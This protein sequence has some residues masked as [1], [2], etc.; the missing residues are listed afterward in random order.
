MEF[1]H[2]LILLGAGFAAGFVAGLVG[3][4]GGVIFAPVL[5]FYF[6]AIGIP[7]DLI[8]QLTIGSSLFC[9]MLVAIASAWTQHGKDTIITRI[10]AVAG[11]LS[12]FA[13]LLT[14]RYITTQPWYS[15]AI[16][17]V[18]FS[19][20]LLTVAVRMLLSRSKS[21]R[22]DAEDGRRRPSWPALAGTGTVAGAVS[23]ATG[24]GGGVI[25]VPA[26][27][28]FMRLPIHIAAGTS[29][30]TIVIISLAGVVNYAL[31]GWGATDLA[32]TIGYVNVPH[33]LVLAV[34]SLLT[35]NLGVHV[36]HRMNQLALRLAFACLAAVVALRLMMNA[37]G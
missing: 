26:Y 32:G 25:L 13:V 31:V 24:V 3:V 15:A 2:L 36:A 35:A 27:S 18:V 34:P 1:T 19:V 23:A 6:Q 8:A 17:Q 22:P 33:A 29:S 21:E 4:G 16:F 28:Y 10:A 7:A 11:F 12:A 20:V 9:T 37:L 5:F 30:A 14:T